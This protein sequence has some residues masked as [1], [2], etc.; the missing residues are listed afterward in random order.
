MSLPVFWFYY[1]KRSGKPIRGCFEV[2][3]WVHKMYDTKLNICYT[4][5]NINQMSNFGNLLWRVVAKTPN[6]NCGRAKIGHACKQFWSNPFQL[7][8]GNLWLWRLCWTCQL[9][10]YFCPIFI[11]KSSMC[12]SL[13]LRMTRQVYFKFVFGKDNVYC[14]WHIYDA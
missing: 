14:I 11:A 7:K 9:S 10:T 1:V 2:R 12:W 6:S 13:K 5:R 4:F 3:G 8:M